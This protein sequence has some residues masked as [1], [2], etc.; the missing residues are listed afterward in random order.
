MVC[1]VVARRDLESNSFSTDSPESCLTTASFKHSFKHRHSEAL[2]PENLSS[3]SL[4]LAFTSSIFSCHPFSTLLKQRSGPAGLVKVPS[5]WPCCSAASAVGLHGSPCQLQRAVEHRDPC[6]S[7]HTA[8]CQLLR[9]YAAPGNG[10]FPIRFYNHVFF[11]WF[12]WL[13]SFFG[14]LLL[15][16]VRLSVTMGQVTGVRPVKT[17]HIE[18]CIWNIRGTL[19]ATYIRVRCTGPERV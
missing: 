13:R 18:D 16:R 2:I 4:D 8:L 5:L 11:C 14:S 12:L 15:S 3:S 19:H 17:R 6:T 10:S 7:M 9:T 1:R